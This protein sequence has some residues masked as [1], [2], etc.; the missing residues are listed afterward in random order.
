MLGNVSGER[1]RNTKINA[2]GYQ[3]AGIVGDPTII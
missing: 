1:G 3:G 2:L